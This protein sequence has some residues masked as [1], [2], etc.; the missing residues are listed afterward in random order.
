M[1]GEIAC[2]SPV[3]GHSAT[4]KQ[5]GWRQAVNSSANGGDSTKFPDVCLEPLGNR[6]LRWG[7][8]Q[9]SSTGNDERIKRRG[10]GQ[11]H[12]RLE[13]NARFGNEGAL[14][15]TDDRNL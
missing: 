3:R 7:M 5:A 10:P 1:A 4:V 6:S 12:V 13:E 15:Q 14:A 9:S 8:T 11:S 2:E